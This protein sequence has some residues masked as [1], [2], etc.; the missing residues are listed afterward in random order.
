MAIA[1]VSDALTGLL[2]MFYLGPSESRWL[3][4]AVPAIFYVAHGLPIGLYYAAIIPWVTAS[5]LS[6]VKIGQLVALL[7]FPWG[8]KIFAALL[9]DRYTSRRWGKRRPW[10]IASNTV[11]VLTLMLGAIVAPGPADF[12]W[13]CWIALAI[14]AGCALLDTAVDGLAVDVLPEADR[15]AASSLMYGGQALGLSVGAGLGSWLLRDVGA[16]TTFTGFALLAILPLAVA[17]VFREKGEHRA[18]ADRRSWARLIQTVVR[19]LGSKPVVLLLTGSALGGLVT[20]A[21]NALWPLFAIKDFGLGEAQFGSLL[22]WGM[23]G[24]AIVAMP[25][26][27]AMIRW[28]GARWATIVAFGGFAALAVALMLVDRSIA[29]APFFVAL[30]AA[31][32]LADL[33]TSICL[34]PL[35]LRYSDPATGATQFTV[36]SSVANLTKPVGA[37]TASS[38]YQVGSVEAAL[39]GSVVVAIM[40][41]AVFLR[42]ADRPVG[43][44]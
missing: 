42:L 20:G 10:L 34:N 3:R 8:L 41:G 32:I 5:G 25:L 44:S 7:S 23:I 4:I 39:C 37:L 22:A 43:E 1:I 17:A 35:R 15:G 38:A 29:A 9:M 14:S 36:Y 27:T 30:T 18:T 2:L 16:Q 31:W 19:S 28:L 11:I 26:G 24:S 13:L 21:F 40:T 6:P 12:D 33:L